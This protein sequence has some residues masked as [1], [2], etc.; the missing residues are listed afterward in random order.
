MDIYRAKMIE[1]DDW[2][3][4]IQRFCDKWTEFKDGLMLMDFTDLI[5]SA[6]G[7]AYAPGNPRVMIVDEA[8]DLTHYNCS[9]CVDGARKWTGSS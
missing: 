4:T 9:L 2:P 1:K 8:Q 5:E 3:L 7:F 6:C